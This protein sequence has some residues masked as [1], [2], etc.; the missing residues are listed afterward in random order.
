MAELKQCAVEYFNLVLGSGEECERYW[1]TVLL[2]LVVQKFD[3]GHKT[4]PST[5]Q[6][7][8]ARRRVV[9][10]SVERGTNDGGGCVL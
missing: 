8:A 3:Y 6:Q 5:A 9:V 10:S 4:E 1:K 2:P 7:G